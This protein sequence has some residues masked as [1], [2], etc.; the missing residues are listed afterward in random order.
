MCVDIT[1]GF[2]APA[3]SLLN[4]RPCKKE[5]SIENSHFLSESFAFLFILFAKVNLLSVL[6]PFVHI[7]KVEYKAVPIALFIWGNAQ[8]KKMHMYEKGREKERGR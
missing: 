1:N 5:K 6:F 8:R 3:L 4:N 7:Y 2:Y